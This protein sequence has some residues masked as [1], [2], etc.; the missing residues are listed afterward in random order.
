MIYGKVAKKLAEKGFAVTPLRGKAPV[1]NGWE[2]TTP[3]TVRTDSKFAKYNI[4]LLCGRPSGLIV[5]DVDTP[6]REL[7]LKMY[8]VLP[9]TPLMKKGKK[10]INFFYRY[11]GEDTLKIHNPIDKRKVELEIISTGRQT[12]IPRSIH[13]ESKKP[14]IW[15]DKNGDESNTHLLN[16]ERSQ[17]PPLPSEVIIELKRIIAEH[18]EGAAKEIQEKKAQVGVGS[19][20]DNFDKLNHKD[21]PDYNPKRLEDIPEGYRDRCRS[22][23]HDSIIAYMMAMIN[24]GMAK[25]QVIDEA[26]RYDGN[27]NRGYVC[28]Y[29][30]CKTNQAKGDTPWQKAEYYYNSCY[31]TVAQKKKEAGEEMPEERVV[32]ELEPAKE[33][34]AVNNVLREYGINYDSSFLSI[35]DPETFQLMKEGKKDFFMYDG[36]KWNHCEQ[37]FQDRLY[38]KFNKLFGFKKGHNQITAAMNKFFSFV[39]SV[40]RHKSFFTHNP[41]MANFNNGTLHVVGRDYNELVFKP[42]DRRDYCTDIVKL[43]YGTKEKNE[44]FLDML[45][46]IF[47][48]DEDKEDKIK[49]IQEMFG[50]AILPR[51]ARVFFLYGVSGSGKSTIGKI[52][53]YLI[54]EDNICSVDPSSFDGFDMESMVNKKVNMDMDIS[55]SKPISDGNFKKI[56]DGNA[57]RIRRKGKEDI[58]SSI[59]WLHIFG[60]NTLPKN[61]DGAS[62]AYARRVTIIHFKRS[63]TDNNKSYDR[64]FARKVFMESPTGILNFAL[65]GVQRLMNNGFKFTVPASGERE[66]ERWTMENDTVA[67]FLDDLKNGEVNGVEHDPIFSPNEKI[68]RTELWEIFAKWKGEVGKGH[69]KVSRVKLYKDLADKGYE[70]RKI[71]G[72]YYVRGIGLKTPEKN[73]PVQDNSSNMTSQDY[74]GY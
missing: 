67:L 19:L 60:A 74:S 73:T 69:S 36:K 18:F 62:G 47:E 8:S 24:E 27:Y 3:E 51:A 64:D 42:H 23:S 50:L 7:E 11:S 58:Y 68:L 17:I 39:P 72:V 25:D 71:Q 40:E 44:M 15:C 63:F 5:V 55:V 26:M 30:S 10:G 38:R 13:P 65:E 66:M 41:F 49:A 20:L 31:A 37:P 1:I 6:D 4:G 16:V 32:V 12:V 2:T 28:N 61:F 14:Y 45:D 48:G 29:F 52:L 59:P 46:R 33:M 9:K 35:P 54:G 22:G 57:V 43:D 34:E 56:E 53:T 70:A 21:L